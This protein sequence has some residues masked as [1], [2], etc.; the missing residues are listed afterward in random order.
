MYRFTMTNDEERVIRLALEEFIAKRRTAT[1][2]N[3]I[4]AQKLADRTTARECLF[5]MR[6]MTPSE[7]PMREVFGYE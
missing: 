1:S 5:N 2:H 7:P 4:D 3:E 6:C